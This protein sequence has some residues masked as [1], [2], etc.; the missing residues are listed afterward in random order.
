MIKHPEPPQSIEA[1]MA[2][3]GAV[4]KDERALDV[5]CDFINDPDVFYDPRNR[6]IW[7]AISEASMDGRPTDNTMVAEYLDRRGQLEK[8]G[9]RS[10]LADLATGMASTS[11]VGHYAELIQAKATLRQ[12]IHAS[13]ETI[14]ECANQNYEAT[15]ALDRA[16]ARIIQIG[17]GQRRGEIVSLSDVTPTVIEKMQKI[18]NGEKMGFSSGLVDLDKIIGWFSYGDL[19]VLSGLQSAGKTAF[20][21]TVCEYLALRGEPVGIFAIEGT[22]EKLAWR[23]LCMNGRVDSHAI[24]TGMATDQDWIRLAEAEQRLGKVTLKVD[25]SS[26]MTPAELRSKAR[27]MYKKYGCRFF[28][29]DYLQKMDVDN[30]ERRIEVTKAIQSTKAIAEELRAVFLV[31]SSVARTEDA[32]K[33][34]GDSLRSK[35]SGDIDFEADVSLKLWRKTKEST[36]ATLTI[37]KN[38]DGPTGVV[39]LSY[40]PQYTRFENHTNQ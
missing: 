19:V 14:S 36:T 31:I 1:E 40:L 12:L 33:K 5:A 15:D 11:N 24:K 4:L 20:A 34:G 32:I 27:A 38:R 10:Y 3:L 17:E 18:A 23:W 37:D 7:A 8:A 21:L 9:G 16:E 22:R 25:D 39:M 26:R 13:Q 6:M 29:L 30:L 2:V 28:V 35:E